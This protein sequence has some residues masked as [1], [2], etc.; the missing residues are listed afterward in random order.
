MK[1]LIREASAE[2]DYIFLDCPPVDI[3]VD[4]QIIA[5]FADST[6]FVV[7]A[8]LFEKA[9]VPEIDELYKN[10]R[11][12]QM[13]VLLNGTESSNSRYGSRGYY[14]SAYSVEA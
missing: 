1:N 10:V 9:S 12:N 13:S 8:G 7:R 3:V 14:A 6:I 2:Y 4:T 11:F 5:P